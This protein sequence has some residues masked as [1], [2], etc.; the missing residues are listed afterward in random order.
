MIRIDEEWLHAPNARR[1]C[2]LLTD[3][4]H[5]AWFVGGCVRNALMGLSATDYDISTDARPDV[6]QGL[7]EAA[8]IRAVPTG[9]EHGT[10]TLVLDHVPFEV[11]TFRRDVATD[12][13][14]AVVA[15]ADSLAEDAMR[16]DFTMNA[17]YAAPDGSI[18]DPLGG[19]ADLRARRVRFIEDPDRRIQEDYLRILRFFRF[20]AWYGDPAGGIDADGL[21]A[22]A[23]NLDGLDQLPAE[24]V[25]QEMLKL[26]SAKDPAPAAASMEASG[27]LWKILPGSSAEG[28]ALLVALEERFGIDPDPIRRLAVLGARDLDR[29]RL[30]RGQGKRLDLLHTAPLS[31]SELG[32]RLGLANATDKVLVDAALS[33]YDLDGMALADVRFGAEQVFPLRA[34]DLPHL[35]GKVLGDKLRSEEARWIAS[36]FKLSRAD[37]LS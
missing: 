37:L 2:A 28:L 1:V 33:G 32:Y 6:V 19:V 34:E 7:A 15:F 13:R 24:R 14:R 18:S 4:G 21:A 17:L 8:G 9:I 16:R 11:T 26:L 12:G 35:R 10:V 20:H 25:G 5:E 27:A 23:A 29:L 3:A 36:G 31:E 30:S 22:C